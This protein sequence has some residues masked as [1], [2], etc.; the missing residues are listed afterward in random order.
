MFDRDTPISTRASHGAADGTDAYLYLLVSK[1][2][3]RNHHFRDAKLIFERAPGVH[4][5]LCRLQWGHTTLCFALS[6]ATEDNSPFSSDLVGD[7]L[8]LNELI[9][10]SS[11]HGDAARWIRDTLQETTTKGTWTDSASDRLGDRGRPR[12]RGYPLSGRGENKRVT[13]SGILQA[14]LEARLEVLYGPE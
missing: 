6:K 2:K 11:T 8:V 1:R 3:H 5:L 10:A 13:T 4:S 7:I 12:Q 14:E 9:E